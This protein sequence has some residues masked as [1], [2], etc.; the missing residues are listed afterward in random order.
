MNAEDKIRNDLPNMKIDKIEKLDHY[1]RI[2]AY[3][4]G[5]FFSCP[6]DYSIEGFVRYEDKMFL[7]LTIKSKDL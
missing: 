3:F 2:N 6:L 1:Y 5:E 7:I 4:Y